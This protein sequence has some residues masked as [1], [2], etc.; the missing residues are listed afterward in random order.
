MFPA[1]PLW[2]ADEQR[3][4]YYYSPVTSQEGAV[5]EKAFKI[6]ISEQIFMVLCNNQNCG[7]GLCIVTVGT[8]INRQ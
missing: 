5:E 1:Y 2:A 8:Y 4:N 3:L 6:R 7:I